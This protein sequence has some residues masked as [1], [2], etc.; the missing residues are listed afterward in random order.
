MTMYRIRVTRDV[1]ES[2]DL[3]VEADSPNDAKVQAL[4]DADSADGW[5][6]DDCDGSD[7][8][9]P[10]PD[11]WEEIEDEEDETCPTCGHLVEDD[12]ERRRCSE[13]CWH[14]D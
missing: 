12:G 6:L 11:D 7:P 9:L 4:I 2:V 13:G 3:I 8:Y 14:N 5:E 1:T 10:D